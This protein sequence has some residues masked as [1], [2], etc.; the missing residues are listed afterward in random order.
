MAIFEAVLEHATDWTAP[1][2]WDPSHDQESP[3][4][5]F[6]LS[7]SHKTV[8]SNLL[9]E[10]LWQKIFSEHSPFEPPN[11]SYYCRLLSSIYINIRYNAIRTSVIFVS[12]SGVQYLS[13]LQ[14]IVRDLQSISVQQL[15]TLGITDPIHV[16]HIVDSVDRF[17]RSRRK[18]KPSRPSLPSN[19]SIEYQSVVA[20][21]TSTAPRSSPSSRK[22]R[23]MLSEPRSLS[24]L[25]MSPRRDLH[26]LL[27]VTS[28]RRKP[29]TSHAN[30]GRRTASNVT[31]GPLTLSKV[32][33]RYEDILAVSEKQVKIHVYRKTKRGYCGQRKAYLVTLRVRPPRIYLQRSSEVAQT[34]DNLDYSGDTNYRDQQESEYLGEGWSLWS[35][36][37]HHRSCAPT[38]PAPPTAE[39]ARPATT[40]LPQRPHTIQKS[41]LQARPSPPPKEYQISFLVESGLLYSI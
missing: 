9:G 38:S 33:V 11:A 24:G 20:P 3:Q 32:V 5:E 1:Q 10:Y 14:S 17:L 34:S 40:H 4:K 26:S 16:Q 8:T 37:P 30:S 21:Q 6:Q 35:A 19:L 41:Y 29:K 25:K 27:S 12:L 13:Q 28:P 18:S 2:Q 15:T 39:S 7:S 22:L 36:S 31:Q 23:A